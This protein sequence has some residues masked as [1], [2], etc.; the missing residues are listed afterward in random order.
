MRLV[1]EP[2]RNSYKEI[3]RINVD[4]LPHGLR[5][6]AVAELVGIFNLWPNRF[7]EFCNQNK[8]HYY[9]FTSMIKTTRV[10]PYWFE[11]V[12]KPELYTPNLEPSEESVHSAIKWMMKKNM[13]INITQLN[14]FMGYRD[15]L[16]IKQ[17]LKR[18][19]LQN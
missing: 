19:Q 17:V 15:S 7:F 10:I 16:I 13:R 4:S 18:F 11:S 5:Y 3:R 1:L 2:H 14:C 12:I 8:L 6:F 9:H